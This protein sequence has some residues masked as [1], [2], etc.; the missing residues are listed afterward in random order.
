MEFLKQEVLNLASCLTHIFRRNL[1]GN[2]YEK[3]K[4]IGVPSFFKLADV[5]LHWTEVRIINCCNGGSYRSMNGGRYKLAVLWDFF[6]FQDGGRLP[7][8]DGG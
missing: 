7:P 6:I 2:F 8:L 3:E 4:K 1:R 5:Y